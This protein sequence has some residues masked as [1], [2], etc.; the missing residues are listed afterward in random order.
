MDRIKKMSEHLSN[1]ISAGEVVDQPASAIKEL[2]ENSIDAEASEITIE[3]R[4]AGKESIKV[5]DDGKGIH[6]SDLE[7]IF[8]RHATS[9]IYDDDGLNS[10]KTL[11]FRGEALASIAAVSK[12]QMFSKKPDAPFGFKLNIINGNLMT[13]ERVNISNGT[14][15]LIEDLFFNVPARKKFMKSNQVET[16]AI[17]QVIYRQAVS[18]P[19]IKFKYMVDGKIIFISQGDGN[20][21]QVLY[22]IF[23]KDLVNHIVTFEYSN[24]LIKVKALMSDLNY[25]RGN[26]QLQY[27]FINHR[28]VE[29]QTLINHINAA[30]KALIP[31][32]KF[33][34]FFMDIEVNSDLVDVNI[35]P[36]K[37]IVKVDNEEIIGNDIEKA[38]RDS[39][40]KK[41]IHTVYESSN[42]EEFEKHLPKETLKEEPEEDIRENDSEKTQSQNQ[43]IFDDFNRKESTS[44]IKDQLKK[45][46]EHISKVSA[47]EE[48]KVHELYNHLIYVGQVLNTYLIYQKD[49]SMYIID[50]HA[51][52][53][54]ILYERFLDL[55]SHSKLNA[56]TL[57]VPEIIHLS[58]DEL[59]IIEKITYSLEKMGFI[60]EP[61]GEREVII[62]AIPELFDLNQSKLMIMT[63]VDIYDEDKLSIDMIINEDIIQQAC[64]SAI[65]AHDSLSSIESMHLVDQLKLLKDPLTCPHGRPIIIEMSQVELEKMFKR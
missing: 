42:F 19:D 62:R 4:S 37:L 27:L 55:W 15:I 60:I 54:K 39:F 41:K 21:I 24:D 43:I 34:A 13:H 16:K 11:G 49:K 65:K 38:L 51:A 64:K 33:P 40:Y 63:L 25:Y 52:H 48:S 32:H 26:R 7:L 59:S 10:I 35:H 36:N 31:I 28:Y 8:E 9:K 6:E 22:N 12:V 20:I 58:L 61:F 29:N 1:K 5:I 53:E 45:I 46:E 57:I 44:Q 50:Q 14:T 2:I 47:E 56:Q 3:I 23:G 18:H 17:N 30:Y